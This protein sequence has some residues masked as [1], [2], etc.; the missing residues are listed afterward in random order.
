MRKLCPN[1]DREHALDTVLEVPIPEEMFT[2]MGNSSAS[3]WQNMRALMR[4]QAAADKS[5]HLQSK[6]D[7][8]FIALLKLVGSPLI[9]FQE[10][11]T[12][13]YIVQQYI[14]AI[15]GS[16]ALNS[17]KS[18]YAVGQVKMTASEMHQGDGSVH[19]GGK[20]EVGGFVLWQKNP[21]LWYLELVVSGYKVSAG[22]DGKVAWNQSSSQAS[23]A[24]RGPPRPLRRFFQGLDPRC[25]ANLFLEAVC[26]AEKA[27]NNEDCFVLK[28][29]T[30]SNTLKAQSSS[31]TEIVHHTIWGYFSQRTGLLVKFEDTKLVK[32]KP[33]KGNDNV[34][35]ETSIESVIGD[36]RYIEGINIAHS[37]KTIATLYRYGASHNH[38]RKIEETWMI[39][40]VDFNICGL[41]MDCFLPPADLKREQEGGEL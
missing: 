16:L 12:A 4:A 28:L 38:K 25:P 27:V 24:N 29:E 35:W 34:F 2:K 39:E 23:H 17:V 11:S 9:P 14:A 18:M 6:S 36:Y 40:E 31:N 30:D 15:G 41:S 22:S 3:R 33:I 7:N 21:D 32:M 19:P 37:G 10:A 20:Y 1:Y 26:V 5:T 13:K 8:E